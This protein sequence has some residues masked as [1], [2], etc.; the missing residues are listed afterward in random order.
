MLLIDENIAAT[1]TINGIIEA[2]P[3][4]FIEKNIIKAIIKGKINKPKGEAFL[5]AGLAVPEVL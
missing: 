1:I 3:S 5:A 4:P 2:A